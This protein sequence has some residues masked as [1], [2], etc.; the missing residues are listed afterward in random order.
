M[1]LFDLGP[2][3]TTSFQAQAWKEIPVRPY[4]TLVVA[5]PG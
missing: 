3:F 4:L 2:G 5:L 1:D